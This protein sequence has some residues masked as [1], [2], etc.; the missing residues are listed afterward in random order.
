MKI[1][2]ALI[3]MMALVISIVGKFCPHLRTHRNKLAFVCL[4]VTVDLLLCF[5]ADINP[6]GSKGEGSVMVSRDSFFR[7]GGRV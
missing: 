7:S 5:M 1:L 3:H 2:H 6:K 4:S